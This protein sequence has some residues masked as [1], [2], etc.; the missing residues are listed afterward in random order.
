ML[1][2]RGENGISTSQPAPSP[3][4]S[5][6]PKVAS[7][8]ASRAVNL[9]SSALLTICLPLPSGEPGVS[10]PSVSLVVTFSSVPGVPSDVS[11]SPS[12][13]TPAIPVAPSYP[14]DFF[15][16]I[17]LLLLFQTFPSWLLPGWVVSFP[18]FHILHCSSG[19]LFEQLNPSPF[20]VLGIQ[21]P[22]ISKLHGGAILV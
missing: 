18:L 1:S 19:L 10:G 14:P 9:F 15:S 20:C 3:L 4:V 13:S 5:G 8:S 2:E 22:N 7:S 21:F 17:V 6:A 12:S 11:F 16:S